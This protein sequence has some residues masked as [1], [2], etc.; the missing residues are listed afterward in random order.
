MNHEEISTNRSVSF[1]PSNDTLRGA[2]SSS[3]AIFPTSAA[4]DNALV[5]N[6]ELERVCPLAGRGG[7]HARE[8]ERVGE[9]DARLREE[10]LTQAAPHLAK[11]QVRLD[12]QEDDGVRAR[13]RVGSV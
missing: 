9:G 12:A 11:R 7:D 10:F 8:G 13:R 4:S 5:D 2:Q 3:L 1:T 6:S